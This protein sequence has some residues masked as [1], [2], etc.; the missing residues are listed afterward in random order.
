MNGLGQK[1]RIDPQVSRSVWFAC[2]VGKPTSARAANVHCDG[3]T[4]SKAT[5][6]S[7]P[8]AWITSMSRRIAISTS[9]VEQLPNRIQITFG[10]APLSAAKK[11]KSLSLDTR[12]NPSFRQNC[13][14][15]RSSFWARPT[16][17]VWLLSGNRSVSRLTSA[18]ERFWSYRSFINARASN[19]F[20]CQPRRPGRREY[21]PFPGRES[22]Q[23]FVPESCQRPNSSTRHAP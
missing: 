8:K 14:I 10:G 21:P 7:S 22:P 5:S 11:P 1:P 19:A 12:T 13:Q 3:R 2:G 17:S 20:H 18:G 23:G 15:E 6:E 9:S 4:I 16:S